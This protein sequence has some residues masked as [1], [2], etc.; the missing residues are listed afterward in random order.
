MAS[1]AIS[2]VTSANTSGRTRKF[3]SAARF[4]AR[5]KKS[6]SVESIWTLSS[7][8]V[9]RTTTT[10]SR[11]GKIAIV[12]RFRRRPSKIPMPMPRKLAISRKFEKKPM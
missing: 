5:P 1:V 9:M 2:A 12:S 8:C 11:T 4:S 3:T 10:A 7:S 6:S